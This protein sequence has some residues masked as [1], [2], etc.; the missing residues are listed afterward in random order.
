LRKNIMAIL[1]KKNKKSNEKPVDVAPED[2]IVMEDDLKGVPGDDRIVMDDGEPAGTEEAVE[3]VAAQ[4]SPAEQARWEDQNPLT[5]TTPDPQPE[6]LYIP[7]ELKPGEEPEE[8]LEA[9]KAPEEQKRWED[10]NPWTYNTPK[11]EPVPMPT[12]EPRKVVESKPGLIAVRAVESFS[13]GNLEPFF[14]QYGYSG[15]W[16]ANEVRHI[17]GWLLQRCLNSGGKF[18]RLD[19]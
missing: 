5:N 3:S 19:G 12:L 15:L 17:P 11:P 10:Q 8:P 13:D 14:V 2:K 18:E 7:G 4:K 9:K 6:K 1:K 16:A